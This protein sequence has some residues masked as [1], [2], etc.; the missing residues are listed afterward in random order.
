MN[1]AEKSQRVLDFLSIHGWTTKEMVAQL[2][3]L[4]YANKVNGFLRRL[5]ELRPYSVDGHDVWAL[6]GE[7]PN[8]KQFDHAMDIQA[9]HLSALKA[10]CTEF[11]R[12]GHGQVSDGDSFPDAVV[13][14]NGRRFAI[15]VELS[16][17]FDYERTVTDRLSRANREHWTSC[18]YVCRTKADAAAVCLKV[19]KAAGP[20]ADL[21][22][23]FV[24][25]IQCD[26]LPRPRGIPGQLPGAKVGR[27]EV[28]R[29]SHLKSRE[30][31]RIP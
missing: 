21:F 4:K 24:G 23:Y 11:V 19:V 27:P 16:I 14:L 10:G 30:S 7:R 31:L 3:E 8:V 5:I 29:E 9:V 26:W 15:E 1:P 13:T 17:K 12:P 25:H 6:R 28:Q 20:H 22:R 2:L 18:V